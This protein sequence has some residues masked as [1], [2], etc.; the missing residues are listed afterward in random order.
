MCLL[1]AQYSDCDSMFVFGRAVSITK[2]PNVVCEIANKTAYDRSHLPLPPFLAPAFVNGNHRALYDGTAWCW[3][4]ICWK[5]KKYEKPK[6]RNP[7]K[8]ETAL[9]ISKKTGRFILNKNWAMDSYFWA[10]LDFW[11][12]NRLKK[13][14]HRVLVE[15]RRWQSDA[16]MTSDWV[17]GIDK[18]LVS[19][20]WIDYHK[21][22]KCLRIRS[23]SM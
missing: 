9:S 10:T 2:P 7:Q 16:Q 18:L 23:F 11:F 4:G 21:S 6:N 12:G 13:L 3:G 14:L 19:H 15:D 17:L 20:I 1:G 22:N 8:P 5:I